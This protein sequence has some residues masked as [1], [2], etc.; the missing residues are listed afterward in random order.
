MYLKNN[1]AEETHG[2]VAQE[3]QYENA[4]KHPINPSVQM[5]SEEDMINK[6]LTHLRERKIDLDCWLLLR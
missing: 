1:D 4:F 2:L 3:L 6:S 5:D